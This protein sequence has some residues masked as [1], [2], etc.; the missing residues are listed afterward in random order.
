MVG[1]IAV[2]GLRILG[3][4]MLAGLAASA[5]IAIGRIVRSIGQSVIEETLFSV[6][7]GKD[8]AA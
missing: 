3:K 2:I 8:E 6:R 4:V 1:K 7:N 5:S